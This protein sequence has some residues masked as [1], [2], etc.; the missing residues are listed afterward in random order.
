VR[1]RSTRWAA[2]SSGGSSRAAPTRAR[3]FLMVVVNMESRALH[4][5][6]HTPRATLPL[7][8]QQGCLVSNPTQPNPTQPNPNPS[9]ANVEPPVGPIFR[10]T[11]GCA[12]RRCRVPGR[13]DGVAAPRHSFLV[14]GR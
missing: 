13:A 12:P 10:G 3:I 5:I 14:V 2:R 7:P 4:A 6:G 9:R 1:V 11:D 8:R